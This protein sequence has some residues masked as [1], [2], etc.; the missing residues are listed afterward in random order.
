MKEFLKMFLPI[1]LGV[2]LGI[3]IGAC[4]LSHFMRKKCHENRDRCVT[5]SD[6]LDQFRKKWSY[7][8]DT[9]L[10]DAQIPMERFKADTAMFRI[11]H[12]DL[13][14]GNFSKAE[15]FNIDSLEEYL[16]ILKN[17]DKEDSVY[18][19]LG[20][21]TVHDNSS[22]HKR[23]F[24]TIFWKRPETPA[25]TGKALTPTTE[26]YDQGTLWP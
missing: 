20:D 2:T 14:C 9:S 23:A 12:N 8:S 22:V 7:S 5:C 4:V 17:C 6:S 13:K 21:S 16:N 1:F 25:P 24:S 11:I 26:P 19:Y 3:I 10:L 18:V 15:G